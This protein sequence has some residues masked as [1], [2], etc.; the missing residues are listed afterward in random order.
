MANERRRKQISR[1]IQATLA[2]VLLYEM[3]DPR[4]SFITIT[5]VDIN[6]DLSVAKVYWSSLDQTSRSKMKHLLKHAHG[7]LRT[8]VAQAIQLR[9]APELV[10]EF[11]ERLEQVARMAQLLDEVKPPAQEDA[12]STSVKE[13]SQLPPNEEV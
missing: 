8:E 11:D 12:S 13:V 2:N 10:F 5:E 7:F 6:R 3:K 1:R 9:T 4:A